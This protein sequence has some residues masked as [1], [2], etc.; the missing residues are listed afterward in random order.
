MRHGRMGGK[1]V[2]REVK[3]VN[4]RAGSV[5]GRTIATI[6]SQAHKLSWKTPRSNKVALTGGPVQRRST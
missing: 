2:V 6:C 4:S 3:D 1:G 5:G